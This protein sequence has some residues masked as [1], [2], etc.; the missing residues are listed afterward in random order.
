MPKTCNKERETD[1]SHQDHHLTEHHATSRTKRLQA[2]R[3]TIERNEADHR[4]CKPCVEEIDH[5]AKRRCKCS[6]GEV[7]TLYH[8]DTDCYRCIDCTDC[9]KEEMDRKSAGRSTAGWLSED[10]G[11][12]DDGQ[13][14]KAEEEE[15][16][17]GTKRRKVTP[18]EQCECMMGNGEL[19]A[20]C[21]KDIHQAGQC[22]K[23]GNVDEQRRFR[24]IMYDKC[25]AAYCTIC[26]KE[27]PEG[28]TGATIGCGTAGPK[29]PRATSLTT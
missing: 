1:Q 20:V 3:A 27:R 5:R 18:K 14:E 26:Q 13:S 10:S 28:A 12:E 7:A 22:T 21:I 23:P 24:S 16:N 9:T 2:M 19:C 25:I 4:W 8:E 29:K 15:E 11:N 17:S 6:S